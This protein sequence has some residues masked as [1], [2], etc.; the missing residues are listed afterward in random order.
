VPDFEGVCGLR[1]RRGKPEA[2][3]KRFRDGNGDLPAPLRQ[4]VR[5]VVA[6]GRRAPRTT[7]GA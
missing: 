1:G 6:D 2:A 7:R 5:R 3:W 4:A